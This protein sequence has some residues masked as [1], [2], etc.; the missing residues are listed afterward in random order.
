MS[1]GLHTASFR[2]YAELNDFLPPARR[3]VAFEHRFYGH[4]AVKDTIE[5]IGVP[6]TE[7]DLIL[8]N[9]ATATFY[10][11]LNDGDRV[12][13]YPVFE[14]LDVSPVA[15][16]RPRPLRK[17]RF[18]LDVHLGRLARYLRLLGFDAEY[19]NERGDDELAAR[20]IQ[21]GRILLTRDR[22]LLKRAAI[23][24]GYWVRSTDPRQQLREIVSR[25]DLA[26]AMMPFSRCIACNGPLRSVT[27]AEVAGV[28]PPRVIESHEDFNRC[29]WCGRV[30][31]QG[32]HY[33]RLQHIVQ[34]I[35]KEAS[36]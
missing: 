34:V 9:Q 14:S 30:Y 27:K 35:A 36:A 12:S 33:E 6:H 1:D 10:T 11:P 8:I 5:S 19:A 13:V 18:I 4:P 15:H 17:P 3:Q 21:D 32:S 2:F 16:L 7:V 29:E 28:V 20:S 26:G 24:R 22:G 25:F 31:W 23:S